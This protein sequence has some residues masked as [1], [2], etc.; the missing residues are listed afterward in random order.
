MA[1]PPHASLRR[2]GRNQRS[3]PCPTSLIGIAAWRDSIVKNKLASSINVQTQ[4]SEAGP[5]T[6]SVN[7]PLFLGRFLG[8]D[9]FEVAGLA[10]ERLWGA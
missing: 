10:G 6:D 9:S 2:L 1:R 3:Q 7:K 4:A 5:H 8:N